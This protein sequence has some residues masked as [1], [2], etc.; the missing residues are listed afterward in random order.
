MKRFILLAGL[1]AI[2]GTTAY[3]ENGGNPVKNAKPTHN[4]QKSA[5]RELKQ[6]PGKALKS[7]APLTTQADVNL[8]T[9]DK[10]K[11]TQVTTSRQ[12]PLAA[13]T[14]APVTTNSQAP[15][16]TNSPA[17]VT[18]NSQAPV[19]TNSQ[20]PV[21]TNSQAPVTTNSQAPV[22]TNSPAPVTANSPAPVT[23]NSPAPVTSTTT[24]AT[25]AKPATS[26]TVAPVTSKPATSPPPGL[27]TL[28]TPPKS[29]D[30]N[31]RIPAETT[32][33]AQPIVL[34]WAA[35]A[36]E[37]SFNYDYNSLDKQ[38]ADLKACYT[39]QGWQGFKEAL[40]KSGNLDAIKSQQL[41][42]NAT[43]KG[44]GKIVEIKENQWKVTLPMQ[45][46]YQNNQ[47]KLTQPLM[48]NLV[49]GRK[50]SG[51]LGIM[52][53]I[54]IPRQPMTTTSPN[55]EPQPAKTTTP[56]PKQP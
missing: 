22:T 17:S 52:Q 39:D 13:T 45:V 4:K 5:N 46:T 51:D 26:T 18:T 23:A 43:V 37:Q 41:I 36:A 6:D 49:V 47:E 50:I 34:K 21:T 27:A 9:P 53:M 7:Q 33:I 24:P 15:V 11:P 19:T 31:Y 16:T 12:K 3:A 40:Q 2:L 29:L 10:I 32:R 1:I 14:L 30:C 35:K 42:V 54:A 56:A 55:N 20:A 8:P 38:L 25:S 44:Q 48:V 28:A